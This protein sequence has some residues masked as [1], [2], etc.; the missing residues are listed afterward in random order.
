MSWRA[1]PLQEVHLVT[2]VLPKLYGVP[3]TEFGF[4]RTT[5]LK[6]PMATVCDTQRVAAVNVH[7]DTVSVLGG[8]DPTVNECMNIPVQHH[9]AER[10]LRF[11]SYISN[12]RK[13]ATKTVYLQHEQQHER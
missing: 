6:G 12:Y 10:C 3:A 11:K 1:L 9:T 4:R 2:L 5:L 13:L 7:V 8:A